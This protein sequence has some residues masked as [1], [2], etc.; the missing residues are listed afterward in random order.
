MVDPRAH[1]A[2]KSS[3]DD[4]PLPQ[5]PIMAVKPPDGIVHFIGWRIIVSF[6]FLL[7]MALYFRIMHRPGLLVDALVA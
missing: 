4:L 7:S 2:K 1:P 5:G 6:L 3:N